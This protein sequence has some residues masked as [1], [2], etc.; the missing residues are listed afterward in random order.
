MSRK[1]QQHSSVFKAKVALTALKESQT[2]SELA[3]QFQ[4]HP[5]QIYKW[6]RHLLDGAAAVFESGRAS[7]GSAATEVEVASLYE[8]IGRLNMELEWLKKKVAHFG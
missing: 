8:H 6:K 7:S 4:I 2:I 3:S 5:N 1:Q